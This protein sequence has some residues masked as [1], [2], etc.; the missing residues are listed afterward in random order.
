M[1]AK[2]WVWELS[3]KALGG[4]PSSVHDTND[5]SNHNEAAMVISHFASRL[6]GGARGLKTWRAFLFLLGMIQPRTTNSLTTSV[7]RSSPPFLLLAFWSVI[8]LVVIVPGIIIRVL[9]FED[10]LTFS[11]IFFLWRFRRKFV[12]VPSSDKFGVNQL[13]PETKRP[14]V[15]QC[16]KDTNSAFTNALW[17]WRGSQTARGA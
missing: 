5:N 16:G 6:A 8:V 12:V 11:G 9:F 14:I 15:S 17:V 1:L 3:I 10:L 4:P 13:G 2:Q 7:V